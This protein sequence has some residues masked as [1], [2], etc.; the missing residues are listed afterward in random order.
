MIDNAESI[1]WLKGLCNISS[2]YLENVINA[3]KIH[4]LEILNVFF[5]NQF[6]FEISNYFSAFIVL[7]NSRLNALNEKR[8]L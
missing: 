6:E 1:L 4:D 8:D 7:Y 3:L 2:Y 5:P